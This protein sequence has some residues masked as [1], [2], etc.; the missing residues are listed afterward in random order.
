MIHL[1]ASV[2]VY[3]AT[4]P[5]DM[6]RSF[7]GLHALVNAV[8][9]LDAF[10]GHLFVFANRRRDRIKILYWDRPSTK[11]IS[12]RPKPSTLSIP[13]STKFGLCHF[14]NNFSLIECNR[15]IT[16]KSF[17]E[18]LVASMLAALPA[19]AQSASTTSL[20]AQQVK[21]AFTWGIGIA[22]LLAGTS[23]TIGAI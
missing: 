18:F 22:A 17:S 9:Q 2:R 7:D 14:Q 6:R 8:M 21:S 3:L 23:F 19:N 13:I 4:S 16:K 12:D 20:L 15:V 5:C 10:A 1:P 11:V